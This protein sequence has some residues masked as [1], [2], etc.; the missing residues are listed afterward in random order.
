MGYIKTKSDITK[1]VDVSTQYQGQTCRCR[2]GLYPRIADIYTGSK[3][4]YAGAIADCGEGCSVM[5][6]NGWDAVDRWNKLHKQWAEN[7][8]ILDGDIWPCTPTAYINMVEKENPDCCLLSFNRYGILY[9]GQALEN[10]FH[11]KFVI[12]IDDLEDSDLTFEITMNAKDLIPWL[13]FR[14][15][16]PTD[17]ERQTANWA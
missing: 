8:I 17:E 9:E 15:H 5:D 7:M 14:M 13:M 1:R 16:E 11:P 6:F 4:K 10:G 2:H 12:P 3:K